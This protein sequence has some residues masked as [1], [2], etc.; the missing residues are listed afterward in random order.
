MAW[1]H[2]SGANPFEVCTLFVVGH[3]GEVFVEEFVK[4][5]AVVDGGAE[6]LSGFRRAGGW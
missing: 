6:G 1:V 2:T 3:R 4:W 5:N